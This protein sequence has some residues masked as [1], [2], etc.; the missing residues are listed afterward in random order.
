MTV[1]PFNAIVELRQYRMVPGM[2]ETLVD[3][4]DRHFVESQEACG[5][6][7]IGQ[8]RDLDDPDR[9]TWLRGFPDMRGRAAALEA[10]YGGPVWAAHRD[11][12]NATMLAFD[13]VHLLRPASPDMVLNLPRRAANGFTAARP[14]VILAALWPVTAGSD[15]APPLASMA[16]ARDIVLECGGAVGGCWVTETA[17]NDWPRLPVRRDVDVAMLVA[18]F[19]DAGALDRAA[20]RLRAGPGLPHATR[21]APTAC[22]ALR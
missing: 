6:T 4:F 18:R 16:E 5:M 12:A 20:D 7:V 21:L 1:P 10:F 8:F 9:F 11:A 17:E 2:R 14:G 22:S 3:L 13:D 19:A 15:M